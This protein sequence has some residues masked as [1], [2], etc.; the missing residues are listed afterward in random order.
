MTG[1][2]V[3]GAAARRPPADPREDVGAET[4]TWRPLAAGSE[5]ADTPGLCAPGTSDSDQT[6]GRGRGGCLA[7]PPTGTE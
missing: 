4:R 1:T 5:Q 6:R 3:S 7:F 2:D